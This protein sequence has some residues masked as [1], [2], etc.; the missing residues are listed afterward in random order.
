V[1]KRFLEEATC[2]LLLV[3]TPE[4]SHARLKVGDEIDD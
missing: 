4:T 3:R 1:L 2:A